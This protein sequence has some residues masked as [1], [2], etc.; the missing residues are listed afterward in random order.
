[1]D[2]TY[3][4]LASFAQSAGLLYFVGIFVSVC[5]YAFWPK[6]RARFEQAAHT[7]LQED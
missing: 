3:Q 7:P 6:N 1:M 5:A 2:T 4:W